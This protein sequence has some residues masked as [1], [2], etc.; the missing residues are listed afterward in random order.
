M[1]PEALNNQHR[2]YL[3]TGS[4]LTIV[5]GAPAAARF[6]SLQKEQEAFRTGLKAAHNASY[7]AEN[8]GSWTDMSPAE[9]YAE[10]RELWKG[11]KNF[12]RGKGFHALMQRALVAIKGEGMTA[13]LHAELLNLLVNGQTASDT[14]EYKRQVRSQ[15][16]IGWNGMVRSFECTRHVATI[17]GQEFTCGRVFTMERALIRH[18][19]EAA[20]V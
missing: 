9:L 5:Q 6:R 17:D 15:T 3:I 20:C 2:N 10:L 8:E 14:S 16:S 12:T 18:V 4:K 7:A 11:Q 13:Q 19:E 1:R